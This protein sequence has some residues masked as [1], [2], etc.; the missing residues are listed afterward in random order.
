MKKILSTTLVCIMLLGMLF[1]LASC[2]VPMGTYE[3][4]PQTVIGDIFGGLQPE[5]I[6]V[7]LGTMTYVYDDFELAYK[8]E[9]IED[10]DDQKIKLTLKK[11]TYTDDDE[12][13][14]DFYQHLYEDQIGETVEYSYFEGDGYIKIGGVKFSKD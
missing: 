2:G 3:Y 5:E 13:E 11:F 14:E 1:T 7:F 10:G 12:D 9:I 8:Y 6:K 4:D